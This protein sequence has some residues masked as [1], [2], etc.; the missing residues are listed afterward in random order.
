MKTLPFVWFLPLA[1][2]PAA[3]AT[4]LITLTPAEQVEI[5]QRLT[6]FYKQGRD[7]AVMS[8]PVPKFDAFTGAVTHP[9]PMLRL[10][11]TPSGHPLQEAAQAKASDA[12]RSFACSPQQIRHYSTSPCRPTLTPMSAIDDTNDAF[13]DL[14]RG[15]VK[16]KNLVYDL[17]DVPTAAEA[18]VKPWSDDY[19]RSKWGGLAYRYATGMEYKTYADAI[20]AYAQPHEWLSVINEDTAKAQTTVA[21]YSPAEKYDLTVGDQSFT[22]TNEEK[23]EGELLLEN[24][25]V[26][27]W[28]GICDGW[29]A[30]AI[31]TPS[32]TKPVRTTGPE[33]LS[34]DW[35]PADIRALL[36]MAWA[37]GDFTSNDIG[38]HC[39]QK[40]VSLYPNG[41]IQDDEC[42]QTNPATFHLALGNMLGVARQSF[43]MDASFDLEVWNQALVR[44]QFTYFNPLDPKQRSADWHAVAVD[45]D[46]DF[47]A[48]DRFQ[49]PLTRG[50]KT[51][52]SYD[53]S[54]IQ[55]VVGVIAT[56]E[57]ANEYSPANA[58]VAAAD[59]TA[60]VTYTYDLELSPDPDSGVLIPQGGEWQNNTHPNFL[61]VPKHGTKVK[62]GTVDADYDPDVI[63]TTGLSTAASQLSNDGI[64]SCNVVTELVTR[65]TG[66]L[67][68]DPVKVCTTAKKSGK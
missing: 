6:D 14:V 37:H 11:L 65:S 48:Q 16:K 3:S 36:S 12:F 52:G 40:T 66:Q 64:P 68:D 39:D 28:E 22:M 24:G 15:W 63:P 59:Q 17:G 56:V 41:R 13:E 9:N 67:D 42:F 7:P 46:D 51:H 31:M 1:F 10:D 62:L 5:E 38:G 30:A 45:Y 60:R 33:G 61:W 25:D 18:T 43:V 32:P 23:G 50:T 49:E 54:K 27:E 47:K 20:S 29:S 44:Y 35:Y 21:G 34:I 26:P 58:P 4:T 8:R 53:D 2:A 55:K 19:W 57:Y